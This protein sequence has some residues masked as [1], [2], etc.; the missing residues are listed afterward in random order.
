MTNNCSYTV[1]L[2]IRDSSP[3]GGPLCGSFNYSHP[4]FRSGE[5]HKFSLYSTEGEIRIIWCA[6]ARD[7]DHPDHRTCPTKIVSS[8]VGGQC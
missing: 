7:K 8:D 3:I 1:R 6:E 2:K 5:D 4:H